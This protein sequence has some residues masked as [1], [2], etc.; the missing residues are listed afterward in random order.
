MNTILF[1]G[2]RIRIAEKKIKIEGIE[3]KPKKSL[4]NE[5]QYCPLLRS[6]VSL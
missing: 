6:F 3:D 1:H 5:M 4:E 2:P